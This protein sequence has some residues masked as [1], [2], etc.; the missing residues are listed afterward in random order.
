MV[1]VTPVWHERANVRPSRRQHPQ[2]TPFTLSVFRH[3][4]LELQGVEKPVV[5]NPFVV[6]LS[7]LEAISRRTTAL[8]EWSR[9]TADV[10]WAGLPS[11]CWAS[12]SLHSSFSSLW[13]GLILVFLAHPPW[14]VW[15]YVPL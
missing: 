10:R 9:L 14:Q 12:G 8:Q 7:H 2:L 6:L 1:P 4:S 13:T 5:A 11:A 3:D 15:T